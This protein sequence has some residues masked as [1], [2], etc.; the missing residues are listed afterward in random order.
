MAANGAVSDADFAEGMQHVDSGA[1]GAA[2]RAAFA[3]I[4]AVW[5][6][7]CS[8]AED[9]GDVDVRGMAASRLVEYRRTWPEEVARQRGLQAAQWLT[10]TANV[11][12]AVC[13]QA[14]QAAAA[15]A[16]PSG[17]NKKKRKRKTAAAGSS[18][19]AWAMGAGGALPTIG[20]TLSED[21][22][23]GFVEHF[24]GQNARSTLRSYARGVREVVEDGA[25][26]F[27]VA[28]GARLDDDAV[29]AAVRRSDQNRRSGGAHVA[30]VKKFVRFCQ[31]A[32]F[33]AESASGPASPIF[34]PSPT[35]PSAPPRMDLGASATPR[36][37]ESLVE[38]GVKAPAKSKPSGGAA[39][40]GSKDTSRRR[41]DRP[42]TST[43]ATESAVDGEIACR[44]KTRAED[45]AKLSAVGVSPDDLRVE[46]WFK[47]SSFAPGG[48][49]EQGVISAV[50]KTT[51]S[52][53]PQVFCSFPDGEGWTRFDSLIELSGKTEAERHNWRPGWS[54]SVPVGMT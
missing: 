10:Q 35:A 32:D 16:A 6:A 52:S 51:S 34:S 43:E 42:S 28:T 14:R 24:E 53:P 46:I 4:H 5:R 39:E 13:E 2:E 38:P 37:A 45:S 40:G 3:K 49:W 29:L 20:N 31:E 44:A 48:A 23:E 11:R 50:A 47:P 9:I 30:G 27:G 54:V 12:Q 18:G 25:A 8:S 7:T 15:E 19:P 21:T 36:H 41:L 1:G 17:A 26:L 22:L 33:G